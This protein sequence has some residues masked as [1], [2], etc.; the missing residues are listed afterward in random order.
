MSFWRKS[1]VNPTM[2]VYKH[3]KVGAS[4]YRAQKRE[5]VSKSELV[6]MPRF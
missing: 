4:L 2:H 6:E 1:L 3:R 5:M